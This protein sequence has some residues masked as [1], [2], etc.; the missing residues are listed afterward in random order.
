MSKYDDLFAATV[1]DDSLFADKGALDPLADPEEIH[2]PRS[3]N[4]RNDSSNLILV[5][6]MFTRKRLQEDI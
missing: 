1:P 3:R 2:A 4:T 5:G 6:T